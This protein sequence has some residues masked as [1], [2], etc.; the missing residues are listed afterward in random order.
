[1][2]LQRSFAPFSYHF[3]I[4]IGVGIAKGI[5]N[6]I[7]PFIHWSPMPVMRIFPP[8]TWGQ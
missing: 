5:N 4:D 7:D 8:V 3:I 2:E 1:M 6:A